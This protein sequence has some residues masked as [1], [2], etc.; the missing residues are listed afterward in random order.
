MSK[1]LQVLLEESE[2]REIQRAARVQRLTVAA[3]VR[4]ALR[5]ARRREPLG[6]AARKLEVIR[7]A[8][9]H[10]LP[11]ADIEQMQAEIERGYLGGAPRDFH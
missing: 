4:N 6:D 8:A 2:W 3:W 7:A 9:R 1:R 10:A 11:T 5:A